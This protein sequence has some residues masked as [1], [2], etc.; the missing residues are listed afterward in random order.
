MRRSSI[1][2]LVA[3]VLC[4]LFAAR[5]AAADAAGC[6]RFSGGQA[7]TAPDGIPDCIFGGSGCY[8]CAYDHR[9]TSGYDICSEDVSG[10]IL[11]VF[12]V[13]NIPDW[14]PDPDPRVPGPDA[15]PPGD[16]PPDGNPGDDGGGPDPGGGGAPGSGGPYYYGSYV[17]PSY[18]YPVARY[19]PYNPRHP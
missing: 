9:R 8:E 13:T 14:W 2:S 6:S 4:G 16:L 19:R 15:P 12:G 17:P 10:V 7:S 5:H 3:L 1:P 11:C 18:L